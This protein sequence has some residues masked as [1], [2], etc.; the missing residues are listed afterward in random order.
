M[1]TETVARDPYVSVFLHVQTT[2]TSAPAGRSS[3]L[4]LP[5]KAKLCAPRAPASDGTVLPA[6]LGRVTSEAKNGTTVS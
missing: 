6:H 4:S 3:G 1:G 5:R 2:H